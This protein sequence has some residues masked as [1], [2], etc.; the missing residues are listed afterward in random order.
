MW[1][2]P[3]DP[4]ASFAKIVNA[5]LVLGMACCLERAAV[6]GA[7]E[8]GVEQSE[9]G[10]HH[11]SV[12]I[13]GTTDRR[14]TA[15]TVSLD[16]EYRMNDLLGIGV[17]GEYAF[18][19]INAGT[20]LGVADIHVWRGFAIQTGPGVEFVDGEFVKESPGA[21]GHVE[22]NEEEFVY[23]VGALYEFEFGR[24][25]FSPQVHYDYS[26]GQDAVIY[27]AAFGAAF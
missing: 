21:P 18:S 4:S 3:R 23:R 25:T 17:V 9:Y 13:G 15:L 2:R 16:Y 14:E 12:S 6:A 19:D 24:Y 10:P 8:L 27:V 20:L 26:T 11:L 22:S 5:F 7:A 1:R